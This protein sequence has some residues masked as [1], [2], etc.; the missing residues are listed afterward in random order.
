MFFPESQIES[1]VDSITIPYCI[2]IIF[3]YAITFVLDI[4][5]SYASDIFEW[6]A[7]MNVTKEKSIGVQIQL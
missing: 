5:K 1:V 2:P 6:V 3:L 7:C 4:S